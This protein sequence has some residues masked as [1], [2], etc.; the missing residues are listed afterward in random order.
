MDFIAMKHPDIEGEA[1]CT[2]E[3]FH[4]VYEAKGWQRVDDQAPAE[5]APAAQPALPPVPPPTPTLLES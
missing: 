4:L 1:S 3:A 5:A 2:E